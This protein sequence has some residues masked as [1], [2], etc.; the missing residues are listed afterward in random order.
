[1]ALVDQCE[2]AG[3]TLTWFRARGVPDGHC[4]RSKTSSGT[5]VTER[6]PFNRS[7]ARLVFDAMHDAL[8]AAAQQQVAQLH[9]L[10][11][12][13]RLAADPESRSA[14]LA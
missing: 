8:F 4:V 6:G 13:S 3:V 10:K 14:S 2:L 7:A 5:V 12:R 11:R 9:R 1:M